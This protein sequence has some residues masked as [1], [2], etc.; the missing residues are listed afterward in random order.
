M[1]TVNARITPRQNLRVLSKKEVSKLRDVKS[2]SYE[3]FKRC[4][5]AVLNSGSPSDDF[6]D[7]SESFEK[8]DI[9]VMQQ[10][11]GI[12]L[13]IKNAPATAFVDNEIV[14]GIREHLFSVL[15]DILYTQE[16]VFNHQRFDFN[17]SDETTDAI[18][19]ILRN[20]NLLRP[21]YEPS[22]VVC[23]GGHSIP[24]HEYEYTKE[25]G[26]ELGL[27]GLDIGT[28]C[29]PGA[30]KGPMKGAAIGHVKQHSG[31]G[32]YIGITEPSIIAVEAPNPIVNEL[33]ILPDI[34]KRLEAFVRLCHGIVIFPG[35]PGTAEEILYL[36]GI[37][38][39]PDNKDIP[40]PVVF[41]GSEC[42]AEYFKSIDRFIG[43][44]LG[45]KAQN[46]YQMIIADSEKTAQAIKQGIAQVKDYRRHCNDAYFFN[47]SLTITQEFQ[48]PFEPTH[49]NMAQ[50]KISKDLPAYQLAANLRRAFSGIVA[51]NVKEEGV[52]A[53]REK[54][55][56]ELHG[57]ADI[58][59]AM[60]ELLT[61][62]V[63]QGRMKIKGA[64][65]PCYKIVK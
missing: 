47:W 33:V 27:R 28:G 55:V 63:K 7:L 2:H 21:D 43:L 18:F 65:T 8:F 12:M 20:A 62:M 4:A 39:H 37:L 58:M 16:S 54:G 19:H 26:Y 9:E 25:V 1:E 44:T 35:G 40:F 59:Q 17:N 51:G 36:M 41:S 57:D 52:Q 46:K 31:T 14:L 22:L 34:E 50:L 56:Y 32:R 6:E 24:R 5:F 30:M 13:E 48:Q 49:E 42:N 11:R 64:Y 38:L 45:A 60:D 3:L 15:R 61:S 53:V 29:G 23:W 10:D